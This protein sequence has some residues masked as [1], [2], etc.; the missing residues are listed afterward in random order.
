M[1]ATFQPGQRFRAHRRGDL[2]GREIFEV[3]SRSVA[4]VVLRPLDG[5][6]GSKGLKAITAM[7]MAEFKTW[8]YDG[9]KNKELAQEK[10]AGSDPAAGKWFGTQEKAAEKLAAM[11]LT[12]THEV[13]REGMRFEL[14]K[15][16]AK[17]EGGYTL[18]S[19][20]N[21]LMDVR[22]KIEAQGQ[23]SDDRLVQREKQLAKIVKEL[24]A[25]AA[26]APPSS[27]LSSITE[28]IRRPREAPRACWT[29]PST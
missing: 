9:P 7:P 4:Y 8:V 17:P 10:A 28:P 27:T 23:V 13:V 22:A 14:R 25:S 21:D 26:P 5:G 16:A 15:K 3:V 19:A 11:G 24:E 29:A 12:G 1:T 18:V 2:E 6:P 20:M